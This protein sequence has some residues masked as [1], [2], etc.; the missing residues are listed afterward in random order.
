MTHHLSLQT[1]IISINGK[2][3][4]I[5]GSLK[6]HGRL[7]SLLA[8][9]HPPVT[10]LIGSWSTVNGRMFLL[11]RGFFQLF[12]SQP[13]DF[14]IVNS[15]HSSLSTIL[16]RLLFTLR[17]YCRCGRKQM[18]IC[19]ITKAFQLVKYEA[20]KQWICVNELSS[21]QLGHPINCNGQDSLYNE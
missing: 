7:Q 19:R 10:P 11:I 9:L 1:K 18:F 16:V 15:F 20:N 4:Q 12:F 6:Q 21:S 2:Y 3:F 13:C 8:E 5:A 14:S 17:L